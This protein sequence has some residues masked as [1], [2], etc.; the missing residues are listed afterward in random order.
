MIAVR[1]LWVGCYFGDR[2]TQHQ[3]SL[4]CKTRSLDSTESKI[5]PSLLIPQL[6]INT[7]YNER[8]GSVWVLGLHFTFSKAF[9]NFP[10][11]N[12]RKFTHFRRGLMDAEWYRQPCNSCRRERCMS[13]LWWL[14]G[15]LLQDPGK[16]H[17]SQRLC[18]AAKEGKE[19]GGDVA[20]AHCLG[21]R[22]CWIMALTQGQLFSCPVFTHHHGAL[23]CFDCISTVF[24]VV[25][26][27]IVNVVCCLFMVLYL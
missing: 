22:T 17:W 9:Q 20:A 11:N 26:G 6:Y 1:W 19:E 8:A 13:Y 10:C 2:R 27:E 18:W 5:P 25:F 21:G 7:T 23:G 4:V 14:R 15:R 24:T 3:S 12:F 16:P